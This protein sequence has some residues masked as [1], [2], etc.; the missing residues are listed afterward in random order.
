MSRPAVF[1]TAGAEH[2]FGLRPATSRDIDALNRVIERAVMRWKLPE[3]VKR[4]SLPS[5]LYQPIDLDHLSIFV[6]EDMAG[7]ILGVAAWE[8]ASPRD[9]PAG[10]TGL[11]LHGL[12]VDPDHWNRGIGSCLL[13]RA[14]EAVRQSNCDGL[15]VKAQAQAGGFFQAREMKKLPV[16]DAGR[17]YAHRYWWESATQGALRQSACGGQGGTCADKT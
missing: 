11:L 6:A 1:M 10:K 2:L 7:E 3:R 5:Y 4:L 8:A 16:L 15:L 13:A 17:D 14:K 9:L 12:Y